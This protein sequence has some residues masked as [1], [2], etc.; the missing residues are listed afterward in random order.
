MVGKALSRSLSPVVPLAL[1]RP[2]DPVLKH[3]THGTSKPLHH[4][5]VTTPSMKK[6]PLISSLSHPRHP[7]VLS[8]NLSSLLQGDFTH[9]RENI[10]LRFCILV[11]VSA[12]PR[13]GSSCCSQEVQKKRYSQVSFCT[14]R[15][16]KRGWLVHWPSFFCGLPLSFSSHHSRES[17]W[18]IFCVSFPG[19]G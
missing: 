8:A 15:N 5:P 17:P 4:C 10:E 2:P 1:P 9:P 6:F 16:I 13:L 18:D 11:L 19:H 14:S 7:L 3:H 12:Q